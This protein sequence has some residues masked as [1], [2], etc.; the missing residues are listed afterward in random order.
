MEWWRKEIHYMVLPT[1][2]PFELRR[3]A[4]E[5]FRVL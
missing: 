5:Y 4:A 1:L 3:Q 2:A